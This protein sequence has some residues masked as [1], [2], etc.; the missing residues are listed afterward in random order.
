MTRG[1]RAA[2]VGG[3]IGGLTVALLL[4]EL[5]WE[6]EVFERSG[7]ALQS[8]GAGI[9]VHPMAVRYVVERGVSDL[10]RV[11]VAADRL[12]Y[13]DADGAVVFEEWSPY[14]FT[15]W[16]T[17]YRT[18]RG[19]LPSRGYRLGSA[20]VAFEELGDHVEVRFADGGRERCDLLVCADGPASTGRS[21]LLPEVVPLYSGYVGWRGTVTDAALTHST[22]EQL[23]GSIVYHLMPGSHIL[24][25]PI[26]AVDGSMAPGHRLMNFVW[27]RNVAPGADLEALMTDREGSRRELSVPPGAVGE[28]HLAELRDAARRLPPAL[29]EIVSKAD[30]PFIQPVM[31]V[32]VTRMAFGRACLLGDAA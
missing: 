29:G 16:N 11:T 26:P 4:R 8:R 31:D 6:V 14:R 25:Y 3:S 28:V 19:R 9:V 17:L 1:R 21:Q 30:E 5:G 13:V 7:A 27:Y 23:R 18:L 22:L 32:E 24:I 15:G 10:D 20:M 2:V 12:R